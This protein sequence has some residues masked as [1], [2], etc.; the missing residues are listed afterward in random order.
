MAEIKI[1]T[2]NV[3]ELQLYVK[4]LLS[5]DKF[6]SIKLDDEQIVSSVYFPQKDA[7]KLVSADTKD[8]FKLESKI[9][10]T[11]KV[12]FFNGS[13]VIDAL[14]QFSEN[15]I[16]GK[17]IYSKINEEL[18]A[19]DFIVYNDDLEISLFCA[20]PSLNFTDMSETQISQ[21]FGKNT[22]LFEFT[23][24]ENLADKISSLLKIDK[25]HDTFKICIEDNKLDGQ[26]KI[27]IK[28]DNYNSI[29]TDNFKINSPDEKLEVTVYKK[30]IPLLDKEMYKVYVCPN[31]IVFESK[32]TDT[33]LTIAVCIIDE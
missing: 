13:K 29:L 10:S 21:A 5:I 3:K 9:S 19:S 18:I 7:V 33:L 30:Y 31:K 2:I 27:F 6:L 20:D 11:I 24:S 8:I 16:K 25:D 17:I 32:D 26:A 14:S 22:S 12:S 15:E 28:G 23:L 1:K 4:K